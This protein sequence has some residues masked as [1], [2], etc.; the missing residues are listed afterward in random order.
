[1]RRLLGLSLAVALTGCTTASGTKG[2]PPLDASVPDS[3]YDSF[4]KACTADADCTGGICFKFGDGSHLCTVPCGNS[5]GC[6]AGS[7][8]RKC[9]NYG[10][11]KP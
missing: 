11:C 4:G 6:P 2:P 1:M 9:N 8:G 5:E 3:A 7:Q 10:R